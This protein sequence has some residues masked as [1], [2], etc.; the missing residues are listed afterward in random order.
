[1]KNY[2]V[3]YSM[4]LI[5]APSGGYLPE[6]QILAVVFGLVWFGLFACLLACL[7]T[8]FICLFCLRDD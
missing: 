7:L 5:D 4:T 1:M 3:S 8:R 6:V 2:S